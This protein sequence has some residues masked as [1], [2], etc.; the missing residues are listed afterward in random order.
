MASKRG[1]PRPLRSQPVRAG[2]RA[3]A[4]IS[5]PPAA[6]A[7]V[8]MQQRPGGP[9]A[10]PST[11]RAA[12]VR[13]RS[14]RESSARRAVARAGASSQ[15]PPSHRPAAASRRPR[16]RARRSV[17]ESATGARRDSR[18]P[19]RRRPFWPAARK[20]SSPPSTAAAASSTSR[21][22]HGG[23]IR[24][25]ASARWRWR[26][27]CRW[28]PIS[29][30]Q[31]SASPRRT[32]PPPAC[33]PSGSARSS[34]S[35]CRGDASSDT[36]PRRTDRARRIIALAARAIAGHQPSVVICGGRRE[37]ALDRDG[38]PVVRLKPTRPQHARRRWT[39]PRRRCRARRRP[40]VQCRQRRRAAAARS[41]RVRPGATGF[42]PS[43][44]RVLGRD[45][46]GERVQAAALSARRRPRSAV[47]S[48]CGRRRSAEP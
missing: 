6:V 24:R 19:R 38:G 4:G 27:R 47:A 13:G 28:T 10:A 9:R 3:A 43:R 42:G 45:P 14:A 41:A 11:G 21:L 20:R 29:S 22:A 18:R 2:G 8:T 35:N 44:R 12:G 36:R 25:R 39:C 34:T 31:R 30:D 37:T 40:P 15:L 32:S 1:P 48:G 23:H 33:A 26:R 46:P 17:A 5:T 7:P 16:R